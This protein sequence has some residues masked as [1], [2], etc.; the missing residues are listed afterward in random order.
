MIMF[1]DAQRLLLMS[2]TVCD[3]VGHVCDGVGHVCDAVAH[4][5]W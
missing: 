1:L 5:L 2:V 3:G 4:G